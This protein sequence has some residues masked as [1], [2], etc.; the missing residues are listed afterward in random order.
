MPREH[1]EAAAQ[2]ESASTASTWVGPLSALMRCRL[3]MCT[4]STCRH[5][6]AYI[7]MQCNKEESLASRIY[8]PKSLNSFV[9]NLVS[10]IQPQ[11]PSRSTYLVPLP[12]LE[13]LI[14]EVS[15]PAEVL[16]YF[17]N[18]HGGVKCL[19][20]ECQKVH[21]LCEIDE[22]ATMHS[23]NKLSLTLGLLLWVQFIANVT[24]QVPSP[25]AIFSQEPLV[26]I[27][28]SASLPS[29]LED[30]Q[31]GSELLGASFSS[32]QGFSPGASQGASSTPDVVTL[33]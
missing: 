7:G 8:H 1:L 17:K 29:E 2:A 26:P 30:H 25:C 5:V 21:D 13:P 4:C 31:H 9:A 10:H 27:R 28:R 18:T 16:R 33:P 20:K 12:V 15:N 23:Q 6:Q 22:Q 3:V 11:G 14:T 19:S 24:A 32:W